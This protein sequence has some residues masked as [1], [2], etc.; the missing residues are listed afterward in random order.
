MPEKGMRSISRSE[1]SRAKGSS[2]LCWGV[3]GSGVFG[4][5]FLRVTRSRFAV[6]QG[7]KNLL[8]LPP[9][10][11]SQ[12]SVLS[13]SSHA[14]RTALARLQPAS[15]AEWAKTLLLDFPLRSH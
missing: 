12:A 3:L 9:G 1:E 8:I 5:F 7:R 14:R 13:P 2:K 11:G 15:R 4:L 10:A 6:P